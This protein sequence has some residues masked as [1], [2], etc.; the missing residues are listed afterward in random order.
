M[1]THEDFKRRV[2]RTALL[3]VALVCALIFGIV[4]L[5]G[6]DWLPGTIIVAAA[7]V[8]LVSEVRTIARLCNG[9]P[10][11]RSTPTH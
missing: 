6:G 3:T 4:V 10:P 2:W 5:A 9:A 7:L 8:G 1:T 11:P